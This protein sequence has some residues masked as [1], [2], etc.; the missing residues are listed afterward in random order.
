MFFYIIKWILI[1]FELER[2]LIMN[3]NIDGYNIS[4]N[5]TGTGDENVVILQGWGT[6]YA[7]YD[8]MANII[9]KKYRVIQFDFPGFGNS[10][11]PCEPWSVDDYALFFYKLMEALNINNAILIGHSYGGRVIIK[12]ASKPNADFKI[13]KIILIDSAGVIPKKSFLQKLKIFRYKIFKKIYS[14]KLIQIMFPEIIQDWRSRQGS[15]DYRNASD[16]MKRCLVLAVNED[17]TDLLAKIKQ[18]TLLIWGELDTATPISDGILME[19]LIPNA[20]LIR[21]KDAG[22]FSFLEQPSIFKGI[23]ESY[24]EIGEVHGN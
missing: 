5:I 20:V 23:I 19:K 10:D 13:N 7:I 12:L 16:I 4:Y 2:L 17:L 8:G 9:N 15:S 6:E 14:I 1:I 21:L 24:F 11:E 22:H 3:I 18:E